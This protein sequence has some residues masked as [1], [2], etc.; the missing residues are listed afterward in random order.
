MR[1]RNSNS[2]NLLKMKLTHQLRQQEPQQLQSQIRMLKRSEEHQ[3]SSPLIRNNITGKKKEATK[4][5]EVALNHKKTVMIGHKVSVKNVKKERVR[6]HEED[7]EAAQMKRTIVTV[8]EV[9]V[10]VAIGE[11]KE[12]D[13]EA[14]LQAMVQMLSA[15]VN[16]NMAK[17]LKET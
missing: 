14:D 6:T 9:D 17:H 2:N 16:A 11:E 13:E 3:M 1:K 7:Q 12:I 15:N 10:I 8:M 5:E 4:L